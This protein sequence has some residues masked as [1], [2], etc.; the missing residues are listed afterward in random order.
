MKGR[1]TITVSRQVLRYVDR[2][3][4][5]RRSSRSAVVESFIRESQQH[6]KQ[7]D[8]ARMAR[9]FFAAPQLEEEKQER[10]VWATASLETLKRDH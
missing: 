7:E 9:E 3:A 10:E 5:Q 6:R 8:L 4:G 2:V 1:V